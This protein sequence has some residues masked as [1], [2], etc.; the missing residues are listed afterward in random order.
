M[1]TQ[2]SDFLDQG[3]DTVTNCISAL[4]LQLF[5]FLPLILFIHLFIFLSNL[6]SESFKFNN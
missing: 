5:I 1:K 4:K 2:F 6:N 3:G